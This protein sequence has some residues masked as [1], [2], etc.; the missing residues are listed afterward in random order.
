MAR[1]RLSQWCLHH[2]AGEHNHGVPLDAA[3]L[4]VGDPEVQLVGRRGQALSAGR[5]V[6]SRGAGRALG[7]LVLQVRLQHH[8]LNQWVDLGPLDL[9]ERAGEVL[10]PAG[11]HVVDRGAV[12][13]AQALVLNLASMTDLKPRHGLRAGEHDL[14]L[15]LGHLAHHAVD[16]VQRAK[17]A[18]RPMPG[19]RGHRA[20]APEHVGG[21]C[22]ACVAGAGHFLPLALCEH[23]LRALV[24]QEGFVGDDQLQLDGPHHPVDALPAHHDCLALAPGVAVLDGLHP[25]QRVVH[26]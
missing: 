16:E 5:L 13:C 2:G 22:R 12:P 8:H 24:H 23:L 7:Q 19:V 10:V 15:L 26:L 18:C 25:V 4:P 9:L 6:V 21:S 17:W 14:A 1:L 11:P 3:E 20:L